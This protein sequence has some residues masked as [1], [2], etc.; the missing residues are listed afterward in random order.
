MLKEYFRSVL[1]GTG[2][3]FVLFGLATSI[4]YS[5]LLF[6]VGVGIGSILYLLWRTII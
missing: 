1:I 3:L 6:G 4:H 5:L 2:I